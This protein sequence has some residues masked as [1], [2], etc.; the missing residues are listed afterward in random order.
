[1]MVWDVVSDGQGVWWVSDHRWR[2][3]WG[4]GLC[5][6]ADGVVAVVSW[7]ICTKC[8]TLGKPMGPLKWAVDRPLYTQDAW[9]SMQLPFP[10][11]SGLHAGIYTIHWAIPHR[12]ISNWGAPGSPTTNFYI[13]KIPAPLIFDPDPIGGFQN[14]R[15]VVK[16]GY[17]HWHLLLFQYHLIAC[18]GSP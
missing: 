16:C 18:L 11:A 4:G 8:S 3:C 13:A 12:N 17:F 6:G 10:Q 15:R 5:I 14:H 7:G 1:M 2:W 9:R